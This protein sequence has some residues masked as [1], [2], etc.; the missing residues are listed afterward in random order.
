MSR[1]RGGLGLGTGPVSLVLGA[2]IAAVLWLATGSRR[3][4][5]ANA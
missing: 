1:Q 4:A 2:V 3:L 5:R